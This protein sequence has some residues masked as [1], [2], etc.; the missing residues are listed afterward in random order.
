MRDKLI[1][2][3]EQCTCHYSPPCDGDCGLCKNVEIYDEQIEHIADHLLANGVIVPSA[4][5]GKTVYWASDVYKKVQPF[6][7]VEAYIHLVGKEASFEYRAKNGEHPMYFSGSTIGK[8]VFLT[9][10]EAEQALKGG[11]C[12]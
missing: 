9:R 8:T 2:I 3:I 5:T 10:E 11:E 1:D 6:V 12:E 4:N 7:V